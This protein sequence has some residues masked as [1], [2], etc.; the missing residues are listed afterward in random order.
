M[1][2]FN[3]NEVI[4][5]S[6]ATFGETINP[7]PTVGALL[8]ARSR[9]WQEAWGVVFGVALANIVWVIIVVLLKSFGSEL[10]SSSALEPI[11][12][13][14]GAGILVYVASRISV[15]AVIEGVET[16]LLGNWTAPPTTL[17]TRGVAKGF[18]VHFINPLSITYYLGAYAGT[19]ASDP[20]LAIAFS[21]IAVC[22]DF[23]VYGIVASLPIARFL[24]TS[25]TVFAIQRIFALVASCAMLFLVARVF[26]IDRSQQPSVDLYGLRD[27][28]MLIGLLVG[29]IWEAENFARKYGRTKNKLLWR[30]VLVWQSAFGAIAIVGTILSVLV[31]IDRD[32]FGIDQ[33][34][35]S[36]LAI[37]ALV[38]A[39]ATGALS[40][41]RA[42]GEM[43]DEV[44][45]A[46]EAD[47]MRDMTRTLR[48]GSPM[49]VF[50]A[51]VIG[52]GLLFT[53]FV[54]SGFSK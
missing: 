37:C 51:L 43:L 21:V 14:I 15:G 10:S 17:P 5:F 2:P 47:R 32:G 44:Q 36:A 39:V 26:A 16:Y 6:I 24:A 50:S 33:S 25:P 38:T 18:V 41:A 45:I 20:A 11:L 46:E 27:F 1:I 22:V 23:I 49:V 53:F 28:L 4:A 48:L 8:S 34:W 7:G 29:T 35:M 12:K 9:S 54:R 3:M 42:R 30:G 13:A 19:L 52:F 40:Y 31:R